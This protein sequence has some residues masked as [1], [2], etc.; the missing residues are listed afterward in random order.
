[1]RLQALVYVLG[2]LAVI[3]TVLLLVAIVSK[4]DRPA[5]TVTTVSTLADVSRRLEL[6]G[7]SFTKDDSIAGQ[8]FVTYERKVAGATYTAEIVRWSGDQRLL[9]L[10]FSCRTDFATFD[11]ADAR[12]RLWDQLDADVCAMISGKADYVRAVADMKKVDGDGLPR[13]EGRATTAEGWQVHVVEFVGRTRLGESVPMAHVL[14][15]H[16]ETEED[17]P[18]S[19]VLE[20]NRQLENAKAGK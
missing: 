13:F 12:E 14:L 5:V 6:A 19:A 20:F 18:A 4:P 17:I 11:S 8:H 3:L 7:Y 10:A 9:T 1:M 2:G 16:L 15:S